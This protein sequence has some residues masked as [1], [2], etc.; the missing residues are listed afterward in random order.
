MALYWPKIK[1]E[2]REKKIVKYNQHGCKQKG[3]IKSLIKREGFY[4]KLTQVKMREERK[5][6][7]GNIDE[8]EGI[9]YRIGCK[10]CE[11][12]YWRNKI[13]NK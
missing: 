13:H 6:K 10:D 12:T 2:G 11:K 4:I 3:D 8:E 1:Q 5:K 9:V 7:K